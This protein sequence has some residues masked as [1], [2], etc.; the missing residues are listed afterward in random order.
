MMPAGV[1]ENQPDRF[2]AVGNFLGHGIEECL[3]DLRVVVRHNQAHQLSV[4]GVDRPDHI[5]P[6]MSA[7]ISHRRSRSSLHP[8]LTRSRI[9]FKA[10]F[11]SKKHFASVVLEEP[12]KFTHKGIAPVFPRI[13][14][15]WLR[16]G[17]GNLALV[18]VFVEIAHDGA[19]GEP[20]VK[21]FVEP[22]AKLACRPMRL[23]G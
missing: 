19:V 15:G 12:E 14:I 7:I 2:A 18:A 1:V 23:S 9:S 5:L 21:V 8:F 4:P 16:H 10:C 20:C 13:P 11:V 3:E 22:A 6:D 17:T